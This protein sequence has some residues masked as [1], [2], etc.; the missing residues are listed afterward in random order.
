MSRVRP[1]VEIGVVLFLVFIS[2]WASQF[3]ASAT[4]RSHLPM[5]T[6]LYV[7]FVCVFLLHRDAPRFGLHFSWPSARVW[8][9]VGL[10]TL[11]VCVL[12]VLGDHVF[13][14]KVQRAHLLW[15][16]FPSITVL[17]TQVAVQVLAV[18]L[19]EEVFFRGYLQTRLEDV[20]GLR[21]CE[22]ALLVAAVL[23]ALSHVVGSFQVVRLLT[24][25][26]GLVFG[27]LWMKTRSLYA[28]I[29]FHAFC[30][31]LLFVQQALYVR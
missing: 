3:L 6:F 11:G 23:F 10:T 19:P 22:V 4:W 18:A 29:L 17:T 28:P 26:P 13:R 2:L 24:F 30:N 21:R 14:T 9:I 15:S 1:A 12:Y 7:P 20:N 16:N 8:K 31:V 27:W 25:F 5:I